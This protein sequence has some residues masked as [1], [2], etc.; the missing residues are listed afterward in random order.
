MK[1][2][3]H[4]SL[5]ILALL[6]WS[7]A[8][9]TAQDYF[10]KRRPDYRI[11]P[12]LAMQIWSTYTQHTKVFDAATGQ[13]E[14]V[15]PRWNTMLRRSRFGFKAQPYD[16][17]KVKA[18]LAIDGVG[19][20]ALSGV[21]GPANNGP[22]PVVRL[23]TFHIDW[24]ISQGE[25]LH[26]M[27]GY[28]LP[29][30]SR[31]SITSPWN[32]TA[33]EKSFSQSYIRR[34]LTGIN[35][36]RAPG[37]SLNG[38]FLDEDRKLGLNYS[39]GLFNP[40]FPTM[41]GNST[42]THFSPLYTAR[43]VLYVGDPEMKKYS[44]GHKVN[45]FGKRN[46]VSIAANGSYQGKTDLFD[47]SYAVGTDVLFNWGDLNVDGEMLW[48]FRSGKRPLPNDGV[49]D[50]TYGNR[51]GYVRAGYNFLIAG[52]YLIAPVVMYKFMHGG[53]DEDPQLDA[54]TV[55]MHSGIDETVDVG[56]NWFVEGNKM[57]VKLHYIW[58]SGDLGA[59]APGATINDYFVQN[60]VG[61]IHRGDF[62]GLGLEAK[63]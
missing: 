29:Q 52:K 44:D 10:L 22:N 50:F 61:A 38:L 20:D 3:I 53:M 5:V 54:S 39:V 6:L 63:F 13:Y 11:E 4:H 58:N 31:E 9:L 59:A 55:K 16:N 36:G 2:T 19:R 21:M 32:V 26:L 1:A 14:A 24:K 18:L 30:F 25:G 56:V 33:L 48:L 35:P 27:A 51:T 40:T 37:L 17:L 42:G 60:P 43:G 12:I 62:L 46:G 49:R 7:S 34:H 47:N 41:G 28:H 57:V 8:T 45:Y 15:D 23:W